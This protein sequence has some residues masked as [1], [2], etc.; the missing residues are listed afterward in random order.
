MFDFIRD[1]TK[2][3]D[4]KQRERLHAYIDGELSA[5]EHQAFEQQLAADPALQAEVVSLRQVKAGMHS[6][7]PVRAPRNF[8]LD[9]AVYGRPEPDRWGQLLP[10]LRVATALTAVLF[11]SVLVLDLAGF[12]R[13]QEVLFSQISGDLD[14]NLSRS[15]IVIQEEPVEVTR[16][17]VET[18]EVEVPAPVPTSVAAAEEVPEEDTAGEASDEFAEEEAAEEVAEG[19]PV[20]EEE[21]A[22]SEPPDAALDSNNAVEAYPPPPAVLATSESGYPAAIATPTSTVVARATASVP[23][24]AYSNLIPTE[25]TELGF[26]ASDGANNEREAREPISTLRLAQYVLGT[27][28]LLFLAALLLMRRR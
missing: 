12:S 19:I 4:E 8:T 6:L 14:E 22:T 9:P 20:E 1:L 3:A 18:V 21:A 10:V 2:S 15:D 7:P 17:V 25:E 26:T 23:G 27:A 5:A 24:N 28:L 11:V 13:P 16:V